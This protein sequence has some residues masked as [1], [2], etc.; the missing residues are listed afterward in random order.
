MRILSESKCKQVTGGGTFTTI[1]KVINVILNA[2]G[3]Y[4]ANRNNDGSNKN[5]DGNKNQ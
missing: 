2:A 5:E 4:Y 1:L 3:L